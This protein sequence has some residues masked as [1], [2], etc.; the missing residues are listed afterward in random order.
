MF[1]RADPPENS[2]A[3]ALP[4]FPHRRR[5]QRFV[6]IGAKRHNIVV[7][8]SSE[9]RFC[10]RFQAAV[11][12]PPSRMTEE[13]GNRDFGPRTSTNNY[14]VVISRVIK[15]KQGP[16]SWLSCSD[17]WCRRHDGVL[18]TCSSEN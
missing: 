2:G 17:S 11:S 8:L 13:T 10:L 16:G 7:E 5:R 9:F 18:A 12:H 3:E 15:T 6:V 14:Y 4:G 1:L